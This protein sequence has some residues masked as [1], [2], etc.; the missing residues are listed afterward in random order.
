MRFL[1][2]SVRGRL[3]TAL[4][5]LSLA[6]VCISVLTWVSLQRVD[7]A[8]QD[9]H[10]RS[11]TQVARA[12]E[13]SNRSSD[14]AT[15]APY[16]LNQRSNVLVE[17]E[18]EK[19]LEVLAT[20]RAEWPMSDIADAARDA[21]LV[22][23]D[24]MDSSIRDLMQ[25]SQLLDQV[26]AQVRSRVAALST[27]RNEA[28]ARIEDEATGLRE[29]LIWW[30]LQSMN[31][32]ALNA[33]YAD[34][35]IGVGEEQR[36]YQRQRQFALAAARTAAQTR[37]MQRLQ[38]LVQ[39]D[40]GVFELRRAELGLTLDAQ[41][42]LFRIRRDANLINELAVDFARRA[43]TALGAE[44][45]A[46]SGMIQFTRLFT[47]TLG[48]AALGLAL[49][50][51]L[52]VSRYVAFNIGRVSEAMVRLAN[53]DRSSVLPR[54]MGGDDEI[55]DLFRSFRAFRANALRLDRSNRL[56]DQRNALFE[57]VFVNITD[58]IALS[59][60][61]GKL[62]ATNPAFVRILGH[63]AI[64]G[65]LVDWLRTS[66][67]GA[68]AKAE[69][70][71][72]THRGHLVLTSDLGQTL[73]I[74][75]S[76]LPDEGRVWL[77]SDVTEQ[78]KIA[79]R[80]AQIDRIELLGKLAGDTAHDFASVLSAIRTHA[81]LLQKQQGDD[82]G[83]LTAIENAVDYGAS[84]TE[85][86]LAFARKQPLSPEIFDL[87]ALLSGMMD[88]VEI[89]LQDAV[90]LHVELADEPIWVQAD[91]GQLE[92]AI[93]NLVLNANNAIDGSGA[94]RI[95]LAKT[96]EGYA[97]MVVSDTG[98]GM[99]EH[100]R[101]KA[102]EPFFTTRAG[103]GGTGLGLSIVYGFISQS[104]GRLD[105]DSTVGAGTRI[106][107]ALPLVSGHRN[108]PSQ[109]KGMRALV[110]DDS[111][112][113]LRATKEKLLTLGFDVKT[114][115]SPKAALK[116]LENGVFDVVVS[117]FDLGADI[118]GMELLTQARA[119]LP[120]AQ[121]VLVSGKSSP[122]DSTALDF[123]FVEKPVAKDDLV[124]ALVKNSRHPGAQEQ[125]ERPV[126]AHEIQA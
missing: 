47:V 96:P 46:S 73:E 42:A 110:V 16:L 3:W 72:V 86:L 50:A 43:E 125:A 24:E 39:T 120:V 82:T 105:I 53:G 66:D 115:M 68:S 71:S 38:R 116:S 32:D 122:A 84:M 56:L 83:N 18:G 76:R 78:R 44:R 119:H 109:F 85:R 27:L 55:G 113:D 62:T 22:L 13:L 11:L 99:P 8:L 23:T 61:T 59:D 25:T 91:P 19:L 100:I 103:Q 111:D 36:H 14:L 65:S 52:F 95:T 107:V 108:H 64:K 29:S 40:A 30:T 74:R 48:L 49:I 57:K 117:D 75:A 106:T 45:A 54:R 34:N 79:D 112:R 90:A 89:G 7:D 80:M 12:I 94:I 31:A 17:Q 81:H 35:L 58:G 104:G 2:R 69:G 70:L 67:F 114:S 124:K 41:N 97:E 6:I 88:L 87:N 33:A 21:L 118:N 93:L 4:A 101:C 60:N 10:Q 92:S 15:S 63:D 98:A 1:P 28:T 126:P 5:L 9:V 121:L 20:V 77:I 51:A 102:I 26:Q 123:T 37:F